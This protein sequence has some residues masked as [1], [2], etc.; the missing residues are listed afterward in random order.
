MISLSLETD[1][2]ATSSSPRPHYLPT[3]MPAMAWP[4]TSSATMEGRKEEAAL[5]CT[6]WFFGTPISIIIYSHHPNIHLVTLPLWE[7]RTG[8]CGS[9][10]WDSPPVSLSS[11][12]SVHA[13]VPPPPH[14][15]PLA[16]CATLF[17]P[18]PLP[19]QALFPPATCTSRATTTLPP[20]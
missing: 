5:P 11:G 19:M 7:G 1:H 15:C 3:T 6:Y 13:P 14:L 8:A 20:K 18:T 4:C 16:P 2:H 10:G 17:C 9:L 12:C